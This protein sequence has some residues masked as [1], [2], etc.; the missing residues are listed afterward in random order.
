[1]AEHICCLSRERIAEALG[2]VRI[3]SG[4]SVT[5][6]MYFAAAAGLCLCE[7]CVFMKI[8][9]VYSEAF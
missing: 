8:F 9:V 7:L 5:L 3:V 4:A 6:R 1:M 2:V